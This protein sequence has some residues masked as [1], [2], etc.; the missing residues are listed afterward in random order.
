MTSFIA[1]LKRRLP[2]TDWPLVVAALR[3]ETQ[4]WDRLQANGFGEQALEA[5]GADREHWSP[6]FLGLHSLS[7]A[8]QFEALRALPM[9]AV[10]EKLRYQAASMYEQWA[11]EGVSAEPDLEQATLLALALRERRRMLNGW[12]QLTDD[13]SI[14][15][16]EY[17]KLPVAILFGVVP[18]PQELLASLLAPS[19]SAEMQGLGLHALLSNPLPLDQ[20][21]THLMEIIS[22]YALPQ[23]LGLLRHLARVNAPLAQ[24]AALHVLESLQESN[25]E[26]ANELSQ[27]ER[28]LLQAEIQQ[29]SGQS[30]QSMSLLNNAWEVA[31]RFQSGL[32]AKMAES[33]AQNGDLSGGLAA[34]QASGE[35]PD[36]KH[37][38][39]LK[40]SKKEQKHPALL[41]SAARVAMKS[42]DTAE[43]EE[44]AKAAL[45]RAESESKQIEASSL[46]SLSELF[47]DL[48]LPDEASKAAQLAMISAP[49]DADNAAILARSMR[50]YGDSASALQAAHL[51]AA[52]APERA[53]LRRQLAKSLQADGQAEEALVEWKAVMQR[54]EPQI[55]DLLAMAEAALICGSN[56]DCIAACQMA[57]ATQATNGAA[58]ALLGKALLAQGDEDSAVEHLRRAT[59]LAPALADAW[60]TLAQQLFERADFGEALKTL[61]AGQQFSKPTAKMQALLGEIYSALEDPTQALA[62]LQRAA[63]LAASGV[64]GS[65]AQ[66]I[67]LR[68]GALQAQLGHIA[69]AR[70]TLDNAHQAYP[71][72]P[73]IAQ[74]FA[75]LLLA[76]GDAKRALAALMISLQSDPE[77]NDVLLDMARA[78][79]MHGE[80]PA[81]AERLLLKVTSQKDA[82]I[83]ASGLLAEAY[84]AQGKH[85]EAAKQFDVAEKSALG[86]N[87]AWRKR[88]AMGKALALAS[89]GQATAAI[90]TLEEMDKAE[91][92]DLDVLRALCAAYAQAGRAE[93][94]FQIAQKVYLADPQD[95]STLLWYAEQAQLLGKGDE[96]RNALSKALKNESYSAA[97][98]QRLA[99]MQWQGESQKAALNTLNALLANTDS[100]VLA[101]AARFVLGKG[102]AKESIAYFKRAIELAA[103]PD[104]EL[105]EELS[106]AYEQSEELAGALENLE[107]GIQVSPNR[108]NALAK[109][110]DLLQRSGRPQAALETLDQALGILPEN[111]NLLRSKAVL[112]YAN[113][114]WSNALDTV[115]KAL[116]SAPKDLQLL[117]MAVEL[118]LACLQPERANTAL[119][120]AELGESPELACL[121]A[122]LALDADE[123][124]QAAKALAPVLET[125]ENQ[126]QVYALQSRLA[127]R[128]GAQ[129]E[130]ELA[131]NKALDSKS[132]EDFFSLYSI[133]RAALRLAKWDIAI[134]L[135]QQLVKRAPGQ[136]LAQFSLGKALLM[137]AEWQQLAEASGA[138]HSLDGLNKTA[139]K[140]CNDAFAAAQAGVTSSTAQANIARWQTRAGLRFGKALDIEALPKSYPSNGAEAAALLY[141]ARESGNLDA[142]EARAK[143]F[144]KTHETLIERA[145]ALIGNPAEAVQF[146]EEA[147]KQNVQNAF[148]RGLAGLMSQ[149]A[150]DEPGALEHIS[151][152]IALLPGQAR[153]QSMAGALLVAAGEVGE[154]V[155]HF[156]AAIEIEP[157]EGKHH[158][159]LGRALMAI[160]SFGEAANVLLEAVQIEP[161][162]AEY[163]MVLAEAQRNAGEL[164]Q[165]KSSAQLAQKLAPGAASL[166]LQAEI[167]LQDEDAQGAKVLVEQALKIDAKDA[168]ALRIFAEAL[169]ALGNVDDAIAVLERAQETAVDAVPLLVRR[170]QWMIAGRGQESALDELVKLSQRFPDRAEVFFALSELLALAGNLKD[171]IQ[172]AQRAVKKSATLSQDAQARLHLH[173]GQLLK[174][175]GQLDLGLHQLDEAA[176]LAPHLLEAHLERGRV[177][178][179]RRQHAQALDAFK[180]AA[181]VSPDEAMPHYEAALALKDAKDY[182][183]AEREL[184]QAAKLAPKDRQIQRQ[185]AAVIALNLVHVPERAGVAL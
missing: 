17:W 14:A 165:A 104:A 39:K 166:L 174:H 119:M 26:Q 136:A 51:A 157:N 22:H 21:S 50:A 170:A 81:E 92:N 68:L 32:A 60:T 5:A 38:S 52:L 57:L 98:V 134:D 96:G 156:K 120:N 150:G 154:A 61:L 100:L 116:V 178:L 108:P 24:Q 135:F 107:R 86:E 177:F 113:Q 62:S 8:A 103:A 45:Q 109:K 164:K 128:R 90:L 153:W 143:N 155:E 185:L 30:E 167:A 46:R 159:D 23:F 49:N 173:L 78:I 145:L 114:D 141:A 1:E 181:S 122:E 171:A 168:N 102:A 93:E 56:D 65:L 142:A 169:H 89:A 74:Q 147:I 15:A 162:Q 112:L 67:A 12:E 144:L 138:K 40:L 11:T 19:Q 31:Q 151:Q 37:F 83:E 28:L 63:Q 54:E 80:G 163:V 76:A 7:H 44:M 95:E 69:D 127:A 73:Q 126:A 124:L 79:L 71:T 121:R 160:R 27:I 130:A 48:Q 172:A 125:E 180:I 35:L 88:L 176:R 137:R 133:A 94:A 42:G 149:E 99:E 123:E 87:P 129:T 91:P 18:N 47:L 20:Q 97:V 105:Y 16:A 77:N 148:Y 59:E 41:L 25:G 179:A 101:K 110:A 158:F 2:E 6:A 85:V 131:L 43:A 72:Q 55:E 36:P 53:E 9:Q 152:A 175:S 58:H 117:K 115:E 66:R 13:L 146:A 111:V 182:G 184:R 33:A 4:L 64:E 140:A 84:A 10:S 118:A 75:K 29:I 132:A 183:E 3:N 106:A 139:V 82:D 161:K 70:R 34:L